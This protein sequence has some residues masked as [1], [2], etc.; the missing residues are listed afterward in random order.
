MYIYVYWCTHLTE[1]PHTA[2]PTHTSQHKHLAKNSAPPKNAS[3]VATLVGQVHM[4][5]D[6][7]WAGDHLQ[8]SMACPQC[9]AMPRSNFGSL[10]LKALHSISDLPTHSCRDRAACVPA[11]R[12]GD[13]KV[14]RRPS[15]AARPLSLYAPMAH[16]RSSSSQAVCPG[17][18][19]RLLA[20][21]IR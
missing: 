6:V 1:E 15:T 21:L 14:V 16:R 11:P 3:W 20:R 8:T 7:G 5:T 17:R 10:P 18:G 13:T 19:D 4:S 2:P 12:Y 9:P